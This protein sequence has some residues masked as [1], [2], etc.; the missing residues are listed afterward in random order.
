M[1]G[2]LN[3]GTLTSLVDTGILAMVNFQLPHFE[4]EQVRQHVPMDRTR[5]KTRSDVIGDSGDVSRAAQ[6]G[7]WTSRP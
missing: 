5:M 2:L 6:S 1:D 3:Y 7:K 4:A